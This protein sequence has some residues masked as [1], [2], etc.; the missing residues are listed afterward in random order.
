MLCGNETGKLAEGTG[1][2][3]TVTNKNMAETLSRVH[4]EAV[5]TSADMFSQSLTQSNTGHKKIIRHI[6]IHIQNTKIPLQKY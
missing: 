5:D 2:S 3:F 6:Y 4:E 1:T